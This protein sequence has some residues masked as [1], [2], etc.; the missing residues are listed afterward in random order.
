MQR[1]ERALLFACTESADAAASHL[2]DLCGLAGRPG[3]PL[4]LTD[5]VLLVLAAYCL[6][7]DFLPWWVPAA[8]SPPG[9]APKGCRVQQEPAICP[10]SQPPRA[11]RLSCLD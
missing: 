5:V 2:A 9:A 6:L 11:Y 8:S 10:P 4:R 1:E 7:P 3:S